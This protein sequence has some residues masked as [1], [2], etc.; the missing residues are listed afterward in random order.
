MSIAGL[1]NDPSVN[2]Q[3]LMFEADRINSD[4]RKS[5]KLKR[6]LHNEKKLNL[7]DQKIG[8]L[9]ERHDKLG[10][11]AIFGFAMN[12]FSNLIQKL[13]LLIPGLGSA[14]SMAAQ[15]AE[16][17]NPFQRAASQAEIDSVQ[18]QSLAEKEDKLFQ[19]E[20]EN[21]KANQEHRRT[22]NH[23]LEKALQDLQETREASVRV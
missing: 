8:K 16:K 1:S 18:F 19:R 20:D 14:L 12:L 23:R 11:G 15:A 5:S 10:I 9:Q 17:L 6:E 13:D 4:Q 21:V 22:I 3:E 7:L 2:I